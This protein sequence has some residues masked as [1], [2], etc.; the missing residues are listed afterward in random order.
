MDSILYWN[1]VALQ[2]VATDF[3][4]PMPPEQKGPTLTA[5]ALAMVHIAMHD[6]YFGIVP[7]TAQYTPGLPAAPALAQK[8]TAVAAAAIC[9]LNSLY[10]R[11]RD[12]FAD[13]LRADPNGLR[14]TDPGWAWG[15]EVA[16]KVLESRAN[17]K[18]GASV[19]DVGENLYA[20]SCQHGRHRPDPVTA[21][22]GQIQLHPRWGEVTLFGV[23]NI[24][25]L[26]PYPGAGSPNLLSDPVYLAHHN[27]VRAK[28]GHPSLNT[29]TRTP[30]ETVAGVFWGYDGANK[31][32]TPPR[33]YNQIVRGL[34]EKHL[35]TEP[36]NA[37]LFFLLNIAMA[38]AGI[39][40]WH[41]KYVYD[42]WRPVV[43]I[44]EAAPSVGPCA[45][46]GA[47]IDATC[48][49]A[50]HPL[51]AP[52][53]NNQM[54]ESNFTPN[55]PAYP[56]GHATFGA[57]AF[58]VTRFFLRRKLGL[59]F[60]DRA[61]DALTFDF[62]SD[63]HNGVNA[64]PD[65]LPR[66]RHNRRFAGLWRAIIEN[67]IS[68]VFLGVHW[69]FDGF[70]EESDIASTANKVGGVPLGLCIAEEIWA[71]FET[72]NMAAATTRKRGKG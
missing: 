57:A 15:T 1:S 11:Q 56:S 20:S 7:G 18:S 22:V 27:Q 41:W 17:D 26:A 6:A 48:D 54:N 64:G 25:P 46:P 13:A 16:R 36:E 60:G 42:L 72:A 53:T 24:L 28:G 67:S 65:K 39:H 8:S 43:G 66:P 58:Q 23:A 70:L 45:T 37:R 9:T 32:G 40:A 51:G 61:P 49:P 62:V 30:D 29:T 50:W 35:T 52:K 44:R 10:T 2:A 55:F 59:A 31:L 71:R 68:R 33:L 12:A 5:R 19:Q 4:G 21:K 14:L 38:D 34:A 3:S 47:P 63:E 69:R